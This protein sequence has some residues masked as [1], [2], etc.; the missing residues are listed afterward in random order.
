MKG[1]CVF[2]LLLL[3][4][5]IGSEVVLLAQDHQTAK[6]EHRY[7]KSAETILRGV[8]EGIS[9]DQNQADLPGQTVVLRVPGKIVRVHMGLVQ[10][11]LRPGD[12]IEVTGVSVA[13]RGG[14]IFL[15]RQVRNGSKV[16]SVRN[17]HGLLVFDS[18]SRAVQFRTKGRSK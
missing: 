8:V 10:A 9:A 5:A 6:L 1:S 17:E 2:T 3:C 13:G 15:A 11:G 14:E 7:N 12:L 16:Y 18:T 4:V